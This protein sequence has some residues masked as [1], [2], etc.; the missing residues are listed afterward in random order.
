MQW[1]C[2]VKVS[3]M[4]CWHQQIKYL[5]VVVTKNRFH[6]VNCSLN[7]RGLTSTE[8]QSTGSTL[9]IRTN[10]WQNSFSNYNASYYHT[11]TSR[12]A[13][14]SKAISLQDTRGR[15]IW[16]STNNAQRQRAKIAMEQHSSSEADLKMYIDTSNHMHPHQ[17]GLWILRYKELQPRLQSHSMHQIW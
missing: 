5:Q 1:N 12:P 9:N 13:F 10:N 8:L 4:H 3:W 17:K 11:N 6:A 2:S 14:L 7:T 15:T 16:G